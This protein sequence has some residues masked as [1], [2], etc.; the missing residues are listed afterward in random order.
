MK[1]CIFFVACFSLWAQLVAQVSN[2]VIG[3][4]NILEADNLIT[5]DAQAENQ[6]QVFKDELFYTLLALKRNVK[7]NY[8]SNRQSGNFSIEPLERKKLSEIKLNLEKGEQL[9]IY[10]F[11]NHQ[12][13]LIH[14]DSLFLISSNKSYEKEADEANGFELK[15]I[16]I[17]SMI[18]PTGK[19]FYD[20][21]YQAYLVSGNQHPFIINVKE[22]PYFGYSSIIS[23]EV[24]EKKIY[25]LFAKPDEEYL[26]SAV[27]DALNKINQYARQRKMLFRNSRI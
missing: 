10:L 3:K 27:K 9:K 26:K 20:Y 22:K 15:G 6:E 5:I 25:E 2:H 18:T 13:K 14:K 17:E 19:N 1:K 16:V 8:S 23:I 12:K 4:I 24:D 7:G 21:F 11:I